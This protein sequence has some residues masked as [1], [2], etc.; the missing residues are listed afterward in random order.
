MTLRAL[1]LT[2]AGF[3]IPLALLTMA[4]PMTWGYGGL[5]HAGRSR[6][7]RWFAQRRRRS[8]PKR[9]RVV[10]N[11]RFT[12]VNVTFVQYYGALAVQET[13]RKIAGGVRQSSRSA[14]QCSCCFAEETSELPLEPRPSCCWR[15]CS[16]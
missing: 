10:R 1:L 5:R 3:D 9:L 8:S 2:L 16:P 14:W 11:G 12:P 13:I 7:P 6:G 4:L 15:D